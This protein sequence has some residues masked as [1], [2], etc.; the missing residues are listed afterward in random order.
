MS[1]LGVRCAKA[2]LFISVNEIDEINE[3]P[4][5]ESPR[6]KTKLTHNQITN[7]LATAETVDAKLSTAAIG[8]D[9]IR[10]KAAD[11]GLPKNDLTELLV[12][13]GYSRVAQALTSD[14]FLTDQPFD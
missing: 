3:V 13:Q 2:A 12:A 8:L 11:V 10:R 4:S 6:M 14:R 9:I 5:V 1:P 7:L